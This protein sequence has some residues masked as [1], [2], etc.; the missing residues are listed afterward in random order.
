MRNEFRTVIAAN[1]VR[2]AFLPN[3]FLHEPNQTRCRYGMRYF[4]CDGHTVAIVDDIE[5][6][7][8]AVALQNVSNEVHRPSDIFLIRCHER[9]LDSG[10]QAFAQRLLLVEMNRLVDAVDLLMVPRISILANQPEYFPEAIVGS[11]GLLPYRSLDF[12]I[13]PGRFVVPF[14]SRVFFR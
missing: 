11:L 7:E 2:F 8:L 12:G 10:W 13:V 4:L 3:D 1:V 9:I 5:L 14:D 6:A